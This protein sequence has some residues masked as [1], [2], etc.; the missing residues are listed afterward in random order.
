[1]N[2]SLR[3]L[4]DM[5][6]AAPDEHMVKN[7]VKMF[8]KSL[9]FDRFAYL[10]TEGLEVRTFNSYP[11][12]WQDTYLAGG[13]ARIDPVVT[14]AKRRREPFIWSAEDWP[15]SGSSPLRRFRDEAIDHKIRCGVTIPVEGSFG[16]MMMLTLASSR[17]RA[18]STELFDSQSA[19]R[20]VLAVHYSLKIVA[21]KTIVAP[22]RML[23]PREHMCVVWAMKGRNTPETAMLTGINARTVQH[24]LDTAREKL[25][26]R[27]VTQLIGNAKDRGL[28]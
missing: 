23:S 14:E 15:A 6:E 10:Q 20:A 5:L 17:R 21:G 18:D 11:E 2:E 22:R 27:T 4:I 25:N 24:Y 19:I 8:A 26:A 28:I 9:G 13:Y 1:M 12:V 3:P 16:S 7:A